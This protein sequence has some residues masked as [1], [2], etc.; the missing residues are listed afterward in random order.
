MVSIMVILLGEHSPKPGSILESYLR[1]HHWGRMWGR[2][3][4]RRLHD[5]ELF[6]FDNGAYSA[7][8]NNTSFPK[9]K[10]LLRLIDA[11]HQPRH[12]CVLAVAPD[13]VGGGKDSL[14][15][16][17]R[18]RRCLPNEL[19]WYLAVQDGMTPRMVRHH[20]T[21]FRGVF[22][23]GSDDF[24][25]HAKEWCDFAHDEGKRFHWGRCRSIRNVEDAW[26]MDADSIDST[27]PVRAIT[28]GEEARGR[29]WLNVARRGP[30]QKMLF[31]ED[32]DE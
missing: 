3:K 15:F 21:P 2:D 27:R 4:V 6:G 26:L 5:G 16:S 8:V 31:E 19:P 9:K 13:I 30:L 23:G 32:R 12:A 28:H 14:W 20:M 25:R 24:K 7:W 22:L 10:F 18:W 1:L 29:E 17:I 11:L